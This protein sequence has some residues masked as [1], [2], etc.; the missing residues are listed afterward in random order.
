MQ[1]VVAVAFQ[2]G[3]L[4]LGVILRILEHVRIVPLRLRPLL[5]QHVQAVLRRLDLQ[6][7]GIRHFLRRRSRALELCLP[8][9]AE[10]LD[11]LAQDVVRGQDGVALVVVA[12]DHVRDGRGERL[13]GGRDLLGRGRAALQHRKSLFRAGACLAERLHL[14]LQALE[15]LGQLFRWGLGV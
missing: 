10:Q 13:L 15:F 2:Q 4:L 1:G 14:V 12:D 8:L 11:V 9:L 5:A 3:A 7:C 6:L